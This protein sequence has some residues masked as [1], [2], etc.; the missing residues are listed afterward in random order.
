MFQLPTFLHGENS[1]SEVGL[2]GSDIT[3]KQLISENDETA[4][5]Q[6][7]AEAGILV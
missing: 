1:C 7:R 6:L 4:R 5:N 3:A 2:A